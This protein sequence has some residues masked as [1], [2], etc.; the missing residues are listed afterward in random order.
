MSI[1]SDY[2]FI[3]WRQK[4]FTALW[5]IFTQRRFAWSTPRA[6]ASHE[7]FRTNDRINMQFSQIFPDPPSDFSQT[8]SKTYSVPS[9]AEIFHDRETILN[10]LNGD[11]RRRTNARRTLTIATPRRAIVSPLALDAWLAGTRATKPFVIFPLVLDECLFWVCAEIW[12]ASGPQSLR[13]M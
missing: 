8:P 7:I 9:S 13:S 4:I 5:I 3:V 10:G 2:S 6:F 12:G 11:K 1:N